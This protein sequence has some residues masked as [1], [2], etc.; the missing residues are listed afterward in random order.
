MRDKTIKGLMIIGTNKYKEILYKEDKEDP[1]NMIAYFNYDNSNYNLDEFMR[2]NY[3][4]NS[5]L[6]NKGYHAQLLS[7][8]F[9]GL[10]ISLS[11]SGDFLKVFRY[12]SIDSE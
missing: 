1:E 5:E 4:N 3:C 10:L 6:F 8:A 7:S 11:D 2:T 9:S 12:Y